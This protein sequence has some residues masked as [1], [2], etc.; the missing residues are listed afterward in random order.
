MPARKV[1]TDPRET[2]FTLSELVDEI[3]MNRPASKP[4]GMGMSW[5]RF[6]LMIVTS[7]ALMFLLMYQLVYESDHLFF[8]L[9][10]FIA[11][12]AMGCL[13]AVIM[14]AFMWSKFEGAV[15][16]W[17][18]LSIGA[19]AATTLIMINRNQALVSDLGF[20]EAMIPHHSIAIN[21]ARKATI[22]DPRVRELADQIIAGQVR[23]IEEMKLL[24]EDIEKHGSRGREPLPARKAAV[25][26]SMETRIREA[27]R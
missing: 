7:V 10:R 14:L 13:M 9:N 24:I 18:T 3:E 5:G 11:S 26:A 19:I 22:R 8:S 20:M 12:L 25:T 6:A 27:T 15:A 4:H 2:I 16:K 21:N 17:T 1:S 23:E